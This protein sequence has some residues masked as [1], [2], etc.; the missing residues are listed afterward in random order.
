MDTNRITGLS[1]DDHKL[2]SRCM[3]GVVADAH[4]L[5][6]EGAYMIRGFSGNQSSGCKQ[7]HPYRIAHIRY[8][9]CRQSLETSR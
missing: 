4:D 3:S 5:G 1:S 2:A 9:Y 8:K 6:T 7:V